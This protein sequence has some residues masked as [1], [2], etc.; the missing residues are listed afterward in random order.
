[1]PLLLLVVVSLL[2]KRI[3]SVCISRNVELI[4]A[5][6]FWFH[7]KITIVAGLPGI[8][9]RHQQQRLRGA[10]G[11]GVDDDGQCRDLTLLPFVHR[12]MHRQTVA[13]HPVSSRFRERIDPF[14]FVLPLFLRLQ[15]HDHKVLGRSQQHYP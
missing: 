4:C 11:T 8:Q 10:E 13:L 12:V 7:F 14:L 2:L 15:V 1:M 3:S 6:S 9:L 5:G